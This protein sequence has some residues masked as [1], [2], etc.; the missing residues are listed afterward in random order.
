MSHSLQ[1]LLD[2]AQT[3]RD[4][5][6]LALAAA[7]ERSRSLRLQHQQLLD[8]RDD[9][10]ARSPTQRGQTAPIERVRGHH[11]FMQRLDQAIAQ[12]Q[13]TLVLGDAQELRCRQQLL[14]QET[15]LASVR[16]LIERRMKELRSQADRLEQRRS[17][18][19]A[20]QRHWRDSA[21]NRAQTS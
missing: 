10:A 19:A 21:Q 7:E 9:Y 3:L 13:A 6:S 4:E 1:A 20:T 17:D 12:Q 11:G 2:H 14:A 5:A 16:K 15:R 8:Y 18:E